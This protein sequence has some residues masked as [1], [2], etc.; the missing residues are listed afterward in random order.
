MRGRALISYIYMLQRAADGAGGG[1]GAADG[2]GGG[3]GWV[4]LGWGPHFKIEP[5]ETE[6]FCSPHLIESGFLNFFLCLSCQLA[7]KYMSQNRTGVRQQFNRR[8]LLGITAGELGESRLM[9][10][11]FNFFQST[12]FSDGS[13]NHKTC[14]D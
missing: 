10:K 8:R 2:E 11:F 7:R 3:R 6:L 4:G 1:S 9:T 5:I 13:V 12:L 14:F